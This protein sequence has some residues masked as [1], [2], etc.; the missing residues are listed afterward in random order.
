MSHL[1]E[2]LGR[3]LNGDVGDML[4]RYFWSP[5][6]VGIEQLRERCAAHPE[7]PDVQFQ[8]GVV[9]SLGEEVAVE[10]E[11]DVDC[12]GLGLCVARLL[13]TRLKMG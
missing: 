10:T 6:A 4:D 12:P 7:W 1:L 5:Q 3:G 2:V 9:D 8:I 13:V 11:I